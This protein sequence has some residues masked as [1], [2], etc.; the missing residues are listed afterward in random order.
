MLFAIKWHYDKAKK[1]NAT[2]KP[3]AV[4]IAGA[5][6]AAVFV[7]AVLIL[8]FLTFSVSRM[9]DLDLTIP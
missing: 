2:E 3:R 5:K 8:L 4:Q 1:E 6:V 7:L 9:L